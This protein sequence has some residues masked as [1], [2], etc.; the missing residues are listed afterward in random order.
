MKLTAKMRRAQRA[1]VKPWQ[2]V[3]LTNTFSRGIKN[4]SDDQLQY[5][6]IEASNRGVEAEDVT[7]ECSVGTPMLANSLLS[8]CR[9]EERNSG[10]T[11]EFDQ[12]NWL[13]SAD[14]IMAGRD[15]HHLVLAAGIHTLL[16]ADSL[17]VI[18]SFHPR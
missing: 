11:I 5:L 10:A 1:N 18:V 14:R 16:P 17:V 13:Y 2:A 7:H 15:K 6:V 8:I 9:I 12:P 4:T 3:W